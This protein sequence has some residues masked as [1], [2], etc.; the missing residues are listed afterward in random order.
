MAQ[1]LTTTDPDTMI[2]SW[3]VSGNSIPTSLFGSPLPPASMVKEDSLLDTIMN[4]ELYENFIS[5][6]QGSI[7]E[8]KALFKL[9]HKNKSALAILSI[10]WYSRL[11]CFDVKGVTSEY[12]G[13]KGLLRYCEWRGEPVPCSA[14]FK[15]VF[16]DHGVCCAFNKMSGEEIFRS[17]HLPKLLQLNQDKDRAASFQNST[18]PEWLD[19]SS[20]LRTVSGAPEGLY[21]VLDGHSDLIGG[22]T[23]NSDFE[24]FHGLIDSRG[25]YPNPKNRGF[26]ILPGHKNLIALTATRIDSDEDIRSLHP[27]A[28]NCR[29]PDEREDLRL[30]KSYTQSNCLLECALLDARKKLS[31][32][33]NVSC[34]P[35]NY[36]FINRCQIANTPYYY[37]KKRLE[38]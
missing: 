13:Q 36:P 2:Q 28:R 12:E 35:W 34:T 15:T 26:Q 1:L 38:A 31:Q 18:V 27:K 4:P 23:V 24:G 25:S 11:P 21:V 6:T 14:I 9:M 17:V 10:L 32:E 7:S 29:F 16:T 33:K 22:M 19:S 37:N 8:Y 30:Y 20:G 3:T 5:M